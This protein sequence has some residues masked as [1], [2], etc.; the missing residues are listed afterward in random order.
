MNT[1]EK[2]TRDTDFRPDMIAILE[3]ASHI[4]KDLNEAIEFKNIDEAIEF[5]KFR[6]GEALENEAKNSDL[7]SE[8]CNCDECKCNEED[9][10]EETE[11]DDE[12][13]DC[14]CPFMEDDDDDECDCI[15]YDNFGLDMIDFMYDTTKYLEDIINL[16]FAKNSKAIKDMNSRMDHMHG[17]IQ[18]SIVDMTEELENVIHE[19]SRRLEN[20][21]TAAINS[22]INDGKKSSNKEQKTIERNSK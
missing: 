12:C 6:S 8:K 18:K 2:E 16:R 15:D 19:E 14:C 20:V 21:L 11:F 1:N 22:A 5:L 13:C 3:L 7:T 10:E 9:H 17:C 4:L